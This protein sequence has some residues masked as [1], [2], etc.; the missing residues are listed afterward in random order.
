MVTTKAEDSENV[1]MFRAL[2][3]DSGP[4][5]KNA[6]SS[7]LYGKANLF[8]TTPAVVQE[9]RDAKA[10][11]SLNQLP[12]ELVEK[13]PSPESLE[14]VI[15][16]AKKTG[17]YASLSTVDLQVLALCL[18]LEKEGCV[19]L[20]HIRS[21]PK[22]MV[23]LG[24]IKS[25]AGESKQEENGAVGEI[26]DD[27]SSSDEVS[28][29]DDDNDN[30]M[31]GTFFTQPPTIQQPAAPANANKVQKSW[32]SLV[33]PSASAD[34]AVSVDAS[35]KTMTLA[36]PGSSAAGGQFDDAEDCEEE[37]NDVL[38]GKYEEKLEKELASDFPSL[39]AAATVLYEGSDD[40]QEEE[41]TKEED[42]VA[43]KM[44]QEEEERERKKQEAL[45]PISKSGKQYN[46][47]RKYGDLM[48][49]APQKTKQA[50]KAA[51]TS[52]L[53]IAT[54]EEPKEIL[55]SRIMGGNSGGMVSEMNA[56]DD[57][58]EGWITCKSDIQSG[59]LAAKQNNAAAASNTGP[60]TS[61][62]TACTT[63]D[64]AMQN[65]LLQMG[66]PLLSVDGMKIRR[67]KSW[68]HRCGACFRVHTDAEF[69]GMKRLFCSH[70]GSDM[71]QRIAAS[72]DGKT[73]RLKLHLKKNYKHNLRGTK[74][75]LPTAGSVCDIDYV[76]SF[77]A[78]CISLS[79][80]Y[81]FVLVTFSVFREIAFKEICC[82]EKTSS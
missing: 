47:F 26:V 40:E 67:L 74:F 29:Q 82:L 43:L 65:V 3:I 20:Q 17:D 60:P 80:T 39:T 35:L 12:F 78:H 59:R 76:Y 70:C 4:I 79:A 46:S 75:S 54:H 9:I 23:G 69:K 13:E 7:K 18:D 31:E 1:D 6:G 37:V 24:P 25:L 32:A 63:T 33:N 27:D 30:D 55:E 41:K 50:P 73:G 58:G 52:L 28:T 72:V 77:F 66:L 64:F 57:D 2:V 5:I 21:S 42:E 53:N 38:P 51:A 62:R 34:P 56:E 71:M 15:A 61:Q 44:K 81:L 45:K 49:P 8:Y 16:F 36:D 48:K 19:D 22:R 11:Q 10:R 68:V 14:Q